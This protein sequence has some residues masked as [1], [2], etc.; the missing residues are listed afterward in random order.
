MMRGRLLE[1]VIVGLLLTMTLVAAQYIGWKI[2]GYPFIPFDLFDWTVRELPGSVVTAGIDVM[3]AASRA[4]HTTNIGAAAKN[5][6]QIMAIVAVL[7]VGTAVSSVLF[8][9]IELSREPS[10]LLG[11]IVGGVLAALAVAIEEHLGRIATSP[12]GAIA[13]TAGTLFAWGIAFGW[14]HD[15][16]VA[17]D[18]A[19]DGTALTAQ[20]PG[21]RQFFLRLAWATGVPVIAAA[22]WAATL[23]RRRAAP[24]G[25]RWSDT[26]LLPNAQSPMIPI[27]GTRPELTPLEDHYRIDTD[28]RTPVIDGARWRL[29]LDGLVDR[30]LVLTLD[31]L[32]REDPLHQFVTL[33]CISN[34]I[35]GDLIGTTRWTGVSLQRV[36]GLAAPRTRATHLKVISA[37]GFA[38][39]VALETISHDPRIMLTYAWDGVP[40]LPEH[41][42]PL[43][44]YIPDVYGMKQPKWI[45]ALEAT[46][47]WEPGYWVA[48]GW[49]REG[50][51]KATAVVDVAASG[52]AG[53][54]AHAGAR[55]VSQVEARVDDG[56]W[57][58]ADLREP[59]SA[60]T[61]VLWRATLPMPP[62]EHVISVR[63]YEGDGTPQTSGVH[64]KR[65]SA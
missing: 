8:G 33:S 49:D 60:T 47:H 51:M 20:A 7:A 57:Q 62:G 12:A 1:G 36:L 43:R 29:T 24:A 38:E 58:Q 3:V 10:V 32:R 64:T 44:I 31:D 35:G 30:P 61:W 52:R 11:A 50:R 53:G 6:D 16:L 5:A 4:V 65:V 54:I 19:S 28:V 40:L 9:A 26:H 18:G 46:D 22:V 14:T 25:V 55:G 48:R 39:V 41:G 45:V 42:Y 56:E 21:R 17:L 63:C 59:L 23:G 2:A 34:P 15:Q 13:W 27:A 37:D